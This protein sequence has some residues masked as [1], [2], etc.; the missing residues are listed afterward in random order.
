MTTLAKLIE[1]I[2]SFRDERDWAQFH[3]PKDVALSLMLEAGE[4]GEIF[5]FKSEDEIARDI[6]GVRARVGEEL[7]DVLYWTLL[8]AHDMGIDLESAFDKKMVKNEAKYPVEKAKG[9]NR[10]YDALL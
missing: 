6:E 2:V 7:S 10:K 5:Q 8:M 9:N 3:K 4:V 1:R